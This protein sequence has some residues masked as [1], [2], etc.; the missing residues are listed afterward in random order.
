[1]AEN[2]DYI[3]RLLAYFARVKIIKKQRYQ[4]DEIEKEIFIIEDNYSTT[5]MAYFGFYIFLHEILFREYSKEV[6]DFLFLH[7]YGHCKMNWA[8]KLIIYPVLFGLAA[9]QVVVFYY[10]SLTAMIFYHTPSIQNRNIFALNIGL[11]IFVTFS[12][13]IINWSNELFAEGFAIK[14]IG[15]NNYCIIQRELESK[16]FGRPLLTKILKAISAPPK[17]VIIWL[18]RNSQ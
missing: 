18:F 15:I 5:S 16:R 1:M 12:H 4:Y 17:R 6:Q 8:L 2:V 3:P 7:E 10:L 13:L 14:K 9:A 11:I